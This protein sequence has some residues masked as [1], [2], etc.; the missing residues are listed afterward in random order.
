MCDT[1][2]S[3]LKVIDWRAGFMFDGTPQGWD[4]NLFFLERGLMRCTAT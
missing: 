4:G 1:D 3:I 2:A